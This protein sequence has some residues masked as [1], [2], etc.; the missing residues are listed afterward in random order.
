M[1][2]IEKQLMKLKKE[3]TLKRLSMRLMLVTEKEF[4]LRCIFCV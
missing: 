1:L 2:S 4:F 3:T